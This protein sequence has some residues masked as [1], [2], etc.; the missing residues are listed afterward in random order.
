[1][2]GAFTVVVLLK[3]MPEDRAEALKR[4]IGWD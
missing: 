3:R 4:Q 2:I 1:M